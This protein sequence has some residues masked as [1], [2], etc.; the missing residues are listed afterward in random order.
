MRDKWRH[1]TIQ[2]MSRTE[3]TWTGA[4]GQV[5]IPGMIEDRSAS[6]LGIQIAKPIPVGTSV[7]V[8][9]RGHSVAA[10][11]RRCARDGFGTL[12]GVSFK[13]EPEADPTS[14]DRP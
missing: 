14:P 9:F 8:K 10:V 12:I 5:T 6:G 7:T 11:V 2:Y 13:E 3:I 1:P 4:D